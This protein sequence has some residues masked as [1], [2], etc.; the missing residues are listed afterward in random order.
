MFLYP[1]YLME[2][3]ER[4]W[5]GALIIKKGKEAFNKGCKF[6]ILL[7]IFFET[8]QIVA[9]PHNLLKAAK[10]VVTHRKK[11]PRVIKLLIGAKSKC[12]KF[13]SKLVRCIELN[14]GLEFVQIVH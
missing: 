7:H 1:L 8:L 2:A 12:C 5:G 6:R 14:A 13:Y 11:V 9:P 4:P 10:E 3:K